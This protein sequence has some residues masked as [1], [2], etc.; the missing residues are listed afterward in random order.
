MCYRMNLYRIASGMQHK[1]NINFCDLSEK[2][3]LFYLC[4]ISDFKFDASNS[5][6]A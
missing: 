3:I 5:T 6:W 4:Q 2:H 1:I